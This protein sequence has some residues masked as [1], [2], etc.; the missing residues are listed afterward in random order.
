MML[1]RELE[2]DGSVVNL[3]QTKPMTPEL[4]KAETNSPITLSALLCNSN[5]SSPSARSLFWL[6]C[7][8]SLI[9]STIALTSSLLTMVC[10]ET[11]LAGAA[12]TKAEEAKMAKMVACENFIVNYLYLY[13]CWS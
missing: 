13:V 12:E 10:S 7:L 1:V 4:Y 9:N 3:S 11:M 8:I 5:K 6:M 2:I